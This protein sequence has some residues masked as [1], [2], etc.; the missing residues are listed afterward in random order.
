MFREAVG[1]HFA[2]VLVGVG[3]FALA[4][5]SS[6][7]LQSEG[8]DFSRAVKAA[9]KVLPLCRRPECSPKGETTELLSSTL[10]RLLP[11]P[12]K[13]STPESLYPHQSKADNPGRS[14]YLPP[15]KIEIEIK[16]EKSENLQAD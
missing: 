14:S 9:P 1:L 15:A 16:K 7:G 4:S 6:Q 11:N 13:L 3:L 5:Q 12:K 8:P 10:P 2:V